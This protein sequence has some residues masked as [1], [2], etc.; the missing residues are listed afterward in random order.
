[1]AVVELTPFV[2]DDRR[3]VRIRLEDR[4]PSVP[5]WRDYT[6][7]LAADDHFAVRSD[8]IALSTGMKLTGEFLHDRHGELPVIRSILSSGLWADGTGTTSSLTVLERR[9]EPTPE[10]EFTQE[11]LLAGAPVH[12]IT[13]PGPYDEELSL[14]MRWYRLP[15]AAGAVGLLLGAALRL[16]SGRSRGK[17]PSEPP[18]EVS[19]EPIG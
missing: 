18:G 2:E 17:S 1:M 6:V 12:T 8:E 4:T 19:P 15:F 10:A 14:L 11:Y 9:F 7:V 13:S 5:P 16:R 3:F